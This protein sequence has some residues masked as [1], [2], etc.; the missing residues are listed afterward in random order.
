MSITEI[1]ILTLLGIDVANVLM[2]AYIFRWAKNAIHRFREITVE[3]LSTD[4]PE[5]EG[6]IRHLSESVTT[7]VRNQLKGQLVTL[8]RQLYAQGVDALSSEG[9][10]A[11]QAPA[12]PTQTQV[13]AKLATKAGEIL[14]IDPSYIPLLMQAYQKLKGGSGQGTET[15]N[16]SSE[17]W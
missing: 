8:V 11:T 15:N 13:P 4:N 3:L 9:A 2:I 6:I 14:G 16:T 12:V 1:V 5:S 17:N 10:E 7:A